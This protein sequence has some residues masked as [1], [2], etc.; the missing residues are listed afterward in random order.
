MAPDFIAHPYGAVIAAKI[1]E[2]FRFGRAKPISLQAPPALPSV[3]GPCHNRTAYPRGP[4][5]LPVIRDCEVD[6]VQ[7]YVGAC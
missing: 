6:A 3:I 5:D 2:D 4:F 1:L 7:P